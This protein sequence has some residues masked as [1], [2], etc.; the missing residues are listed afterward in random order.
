MMAPDLA[1]DIP[2]RLMRPLAATRPDFYCLHDRG[3]AVACGSLAELIEIWLS[4]LAMKRSLR[5]T[6]FQRTA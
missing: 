3:A 6:F 5:N 2:C 1:A 4:G